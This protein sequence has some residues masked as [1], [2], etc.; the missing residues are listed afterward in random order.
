MASTERLP[1]RI[2]DV[3]PEDLQRAICELELSDTDKIVAATQEVEALVS[4][5]YRREW[6]L[7]ST[8]DRSEQ[9]DYIRKV[10]KH[11]DGL[12]KEFE[13]ADP[14]IKSTFGVHL[15]RPL[16]RVLGPQG[17]AA[18]C[19]ELATHLPRQSG[20]DFDQFLERRRRG[21][22]F[23]GFTGA[24]AATTRVVVDHSIEVLLRLIDTID[25]PLR[26]VLELEKAD[27]GGRPVNPYRL[28]VIREAADIYRRA[29]GKPPPRSSTGSFV[30]FC[31]RILDAVGLPEDVGIGDAI[32]R[33]LPR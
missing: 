9:I 33:H 5:L 31:A 16:A 14:G 29:V 27:R 4:K 8:R 6:W 25:K 19:P 10:H 20:R 2:E 18:L 23:E 11:L 30:E 15:A 1:K 13:R 3:E 24:Q 17:V 22:S 12:R 32:I 26:D 7:A 21:E 28:I